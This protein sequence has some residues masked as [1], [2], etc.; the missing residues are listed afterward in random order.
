LD[1][2][3]LDRERFDRLVQRLRPALQRYCAR[4]SGSAIDGEDIV[5][6]ALLK[7]LEALR[8]GQVTNLEAWIFRIAHNSALDFLR[9]RALQMSR[10]SNED[11]EMQPDLAA[12]ISDR[13]TAAASL[14]TFMRLP[15][16]Q[17]SSVILMDVLGHSLEEIHTVTG[18]SIAGVK[19]GLH[20]GRSRLRELAKE[21]QDARPP[22][23]SPRERVLLSAYVERF[24]ARDFDGLRDMLADD[25]R[26]ELVNRTRL[27]GRIGVSKYFGNYEA[28]TDWR[29]APGTVDGRAAVL[30]LDLTNPTARPVSF[31]LLQWEAGR[32]VG[33]RDFRYAPYA[34]ADAE[35]ITLAALEPALSL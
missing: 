27:S 34:M 29:L 17:R 9:R 20:R 23:L 7:A 16:R 14:R 3:E 33:I 32:I 24:N 13:E 2:S 35:C 11:L 4:M 10:F 18:V 8:S 31:V 22:D 12:P 1:G 25:V 30:V 6:D 19:A 15:V 26:L 28:A 21:P 5:Q